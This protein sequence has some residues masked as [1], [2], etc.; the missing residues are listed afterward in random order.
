MHTDRTTRLGCAGALASLRTDKQTDVSS[1][2]RRK[3]ARRTEPNWHQR[4][5][6]WTQHATWSTEHYDLAWKCTQWHNVRTE[7]MHALMLAQACKR[8]VWRCAQMQQPLTDKSWGKVNNLLMSSVGLK[9]ESGA[10]KHCKSINKWWRERSNKH[11]SFCSF[12][13]LQKR[14]SCCTQ[15]QN[16]PSQMAP[17]FKGFLWSNLSA[18]EKDRTEP[19]QLGRHGLCAQQD[20]NL[21]ASSTHIKLKRSAYGMDYALCILFE[22]VCCIECRL[23]ENIICASVTKP[24]AWLWIMW[25]CTWYSE[26]IS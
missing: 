7:C 14:L 3:S 16:R 17:L 24:K 20:A 21:T 25:F 5:H 22:A 8:I 12:M 2:P 11:L 10:Q 13:S 23:R 19:I 9:T 6:V 15:E 4:D 1:P 18:G 26:Q